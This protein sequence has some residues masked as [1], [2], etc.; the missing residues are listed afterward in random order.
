MRIL[1]DIE[2]INVNKNKEINGLGGWLILLSIGLIF[3]PIKFLISLSEFTPAFDQGVWTAL[4]QLDTS[5]LW[6]TILITE[7]IWNTVIF[8]AM[9][10]LIFL[11]FSER[12]TFPKLYIAV[13]LLTVVF[14]PL[15]YYL[16]SKVV[17]ES[18]IDKGVMKDFIVALI[19]AAIWIPYLLMSK[20][21]KNTFIK[22]GNKKE[23]TLVVAT[24]CCLVA[25]TLGLLIH[26]KPVGHQELAIADDHKQE[27]PKAENN[28]VD[29]KQVLNDSLK[30]AAQQVNQ[31][32]PKM[33]DSETRLD[34]SLAGDSK[35]IYKLTMINYKAEELSS[36]EFKKIARENLLSNVC[37]NPGIKAFFDRDVSVDYQ[38]YGKLGNL[39]TGVEIMPDACK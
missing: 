30:L 21:V 37:T 20:R 9:L 13:S 24:C 6:A 12:S 32:L 3:S 10:Y 19:G 4:M 29:E 8:I 31:T 22:N 16:A 11:F 14:L 2:I 33:I 28:T 15:D 27:T 25:V 35:F 39:I 26:D 17:H 18:A 1:Y 5:G 23:K 7:T 36:D 38:Y 34:S